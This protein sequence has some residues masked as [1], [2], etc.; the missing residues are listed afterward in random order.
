[1]PVPDYERRALAAERTVEILKRKVRDLYSGGAQTPIHRALQKAQHRDERNRRRREIAEVRE[2][3]LRKYS[4]HLEREVERRTRAIQT[5]LDNVTFGFLVIDRDLS[6]REGFTHSCT[7]LFGRAPEVGGDLLELLGIEDAEERIELQL[8]VDQVFEDLLPEEVSLDQMAKRFEVDGRVLQVDAR[9][10]RDSKGEV[11][12]LLL[13][14]SDITA[15]E[16]AREQSRVRDVLIR[17]LHQKPAFQH[18]VA[19]TRVV[20]AATMDRCDDAAFVLQV[21]HTVK[22]NAASWGLESI[23]R[24]AHDIEARERVDPAALHELAREL[25]AF[26]EQHRGVLDIDYDQ[27]GSAYAISASQLQ[28]LRDAAENGTADDVRHW[29]DRVKMRP[30]HELLG[31]LPEFVDRLA[32]RLGKEVEFRLDGQDL[33][34]DAEVMGPVLRNLPHLIRNAVDHGLEPTW[35]RGDKSPR[36]RLNVALADE[37][38]D[39]A[40]RVEDDGRG[41]PVDTVARRALTLGL[42]DEVTLAQMSESERL[43]LAFM[44]GVSSAATMTDI[45]GRGVGLSSVEAAVRSRVGNIELTSGSAGTSVVLRVPKAAASAAWSA[46]QGGAQ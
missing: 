43:Q 14:V 31:P 21:V 34:V 5:I 17:I 10:V 45:S 15:L 25:R 23:V 30:A 22:G 44:D 9:T 35:E 13:T 41:V 19:D 46:R 24:L 11:E 4:Q 33:L 2:A 12:A 32:E 36:G 29:V 20:L 16:S 7:A 39:W 27:E 28:K 8:S 38:G 18:F 40:V 37:G 3:E 1:M 6:I 42:V 26:L